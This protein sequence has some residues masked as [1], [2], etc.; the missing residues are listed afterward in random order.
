MIASPDMIST[1]LKMLSSLAVILG[2]LLGL[3]YLARRMLNR[4]AAVGGEKLV[5]VLANTYMGA[6]KS[7]TL[8]E[9]PGAILVLGVTGENISLLARI[10]DREI[11]ERV[12]RPEGERSS[13]SFADQ[14]Q[15]WSSRFRA[16]KGE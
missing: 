9:V 16:E 1:A 7:I 10:E 11:V 6:K 8:V 2:A 4:N 14:L 5:R 3:F 15:R 12:R 13:P